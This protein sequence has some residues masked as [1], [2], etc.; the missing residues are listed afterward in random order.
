MDS[1]AGCFSCRAPAVSKPLMLARKLLRF[2]R[3]GAAARMLRQML[4]STAA[5][6]VMFATVGGWPLVVADESAPRSAIVSQDSATGRRE[7]VVAEND[8]AAQA[9]L[10]ILRHGGNAIDAAAAVSL[11]LGVTNAG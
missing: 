8:I 4:R 9:G 10:E 1:G 11:V 5:A 7:M 6:L 3:H 2:A